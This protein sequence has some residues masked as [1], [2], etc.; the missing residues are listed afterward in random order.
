MRR[1]KRKDDDSEGNMIKM[2]LKGRREK[3]TLRKGT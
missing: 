1:E 2:G 3:K